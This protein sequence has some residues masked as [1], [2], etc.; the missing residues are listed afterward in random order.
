MKF[1]YQAKNRE[2]KLSSGVI[3]APSESVAAKSLHEQDLFVLELKKMGASVSS[4]S[5]E[6]HLPFLSHRVSL[7]DKIILTQ[8][9]AMMIKS[10]LP[11]LDAFAAL[12]E[13]TENRYFSQII[14]EIS[15]DVKGGKPLS[16]SLAK[17]PKIFNTLYVSI[18]SSG[19]KSGKLDEVL[20]RLAEQLQ[21]DY[22]LI[23]KIKAAVT[24]P[25]V[26]MVALVGIV[27]LMLIF[28]VPQLKSVFADIGAELP[29][30][31]R[32]VL[33][34]SD[35]IR[36]YWY[37]WIIVIVGLYLAI[38]FWIKTPKGSLSW[39]RLKLKIPVIGPLIKKIYMA[40]FSRTM[41]ALIASGLPMLEVIETV[42]SVMPNKVYSQA[43]D[44]ISE[45]IKNGKTLSETLKNQRI[46]PAM[47]YHLI[48]TGE[49]SGKIDYI[50]LTMADFFDKEVENT[51]SNLS[52]MIEPILII[53]IGAGV[54]F[55]VAS[56]IM[57]IYSLVNVL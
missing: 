24:Y 30:T 38:R 10:G 53:I 42:K 27:I 32:I 11:L 46:F 4:I 9:L 36:N 19:E 45:D 26:V 5:K 12:Q 33:G 29:L 41:G 18:I 57:P 34:T 6:L 25:I 14:G 50:M 39:D 16:E 20:E 3:D 8:Q 21:K 37:V 31:T 7:K 40:R 48:S 28:V 54:G 35:I 43:F 17:Y 49:K 44:R 1:T 52:T 47:I 55:V 22:D 51:T 23:S 13:Q 2:G 15:A 56:V